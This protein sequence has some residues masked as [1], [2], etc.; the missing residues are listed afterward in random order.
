M[1]QMNPKTHG[2]LGVLVNSCDKYD[3]LWKPFFELMAIN[4]PDLKYPVYL[5]TETKDYPY[6]IGTQRIT[7]LHWADPSA[8]WSERLY[9][10]LKRIP[11]HYV[12]ML[13]DDYFLVDKV[14]SSEIDSM[15]QWMETDKII[16]NV[17]LYSVGSHGTVPESNPR[18]IL[19]DKKAPNLVMC[20]TTAIWRKE[21][22]MSLIRRYESPWEFEEAGTQRAYKKDWK[23]YALSPEG[24]AEYGL[25][26]PFR[27]A[28]V[29]GIG[30]LQGKWGFNNK[31]LF[32]KFGIEADFS[33]RGSWSSYEEIQIYFRESAKQNAEE[34]P[35]YKRVLHRILPDAAVGIV[36]RLRR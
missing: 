30:V 5:N 31:A 25:I 22:L 6:T 36:R 12:L 7:A 28:P 29:H 18:V 32:D 26:Y 11:E 34:I 15:L 27:L 1:I 17:V 10:A 4:W 19:L 13:M 3:D 21:V 35:L 33:K 8:P 2:G 24:V 16:A 9:Q 14:N 23:H 20:C